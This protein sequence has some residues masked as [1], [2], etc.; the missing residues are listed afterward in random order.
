M[1]LA[2]PIFAADSNQI[3]NQLSIKKNSP[4]FLPASKGY[5]SFF[6]MNVEQHK[7]DKQEIDGFN[8][9]MGIGMGKKITD[10][11]SIML[12]PKILWLN[13]ASEQRE[14]RLNE[15]LY[16]I[17]GGL[18]LTQ[19]RNGVSSNYEALFVQDLSRQGSLNYYGNVITG[20]SLSR[21]LS[22]ALKLSSTLKYE[23]KARRRAQPDLVKDY[24]ALLVAA[25][26][27]ISGKLIFAN[28]VRYER[29]NK[30]GNTWDGGFHMIPKISWQASKKLKFNL[31]TT[32]KPYTG[33]SHQKITLNQD[34]QKQ[35]T[36]FGLGR[37]T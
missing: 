27:Q 18:F 15:I 16:K 32:L 34:W 8:S 4:I 10:D 22:Y 35:N 2:T 3:S 12:M 17:S 28:T 31:E 11:Q 36:P 37:A 7:N 30:V 29:V 13:N 24:Y 23:V 19:E 9:N 5:S 1:I 25:E 21:S 26:Y 14:T 6:E 33:N 20:I